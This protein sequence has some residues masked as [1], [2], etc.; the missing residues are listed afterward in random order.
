[1]FEEVQTI[2]AIHAE[3]GNDVG[4]VDAVAEELDTDA[5]RHVMVCIV[6]FEGRA[7]TNK[8]SIASAEHASVMMISQADPGSLGHIAYA[9]EGLLAAVELIT[10]LIPASSRFD[11]EVLVRVPVTA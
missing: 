6:D 1:M 5:W 4:R 8:A 9:V 3:L 11:L 2:L 7:Q 10:L